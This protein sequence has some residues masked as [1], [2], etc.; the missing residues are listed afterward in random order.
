MENIIA[1]FNNRN[2][3]L[4]FASTLKR[5]GI[6]TKTINTPRD[7]SVS[8]GISIVFSGK[9]L[10]Q[11]RMVVDMLMQIEDFDDFIK[12]H[13]QAIAEIQETINKF[14]EQNK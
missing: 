7:L 11:A 14:K 10:G 1:V 5:L 8:C 2:Q 13:P 3:A 4:Q 12:K 9:A 6:R